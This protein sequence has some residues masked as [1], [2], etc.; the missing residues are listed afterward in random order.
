MIDDSRSSPAYSGVTTAPGPAP[1]GLS[2]S[3]PVDDVFDGRYERRGLLGVG[4]MGRVYLVWDR[5]VEREVALKEVYARDEAHRV[6]LTKRFLREAAVTA[7]LEHPGIVPVYDVGSSGRGAYYTMRV[8]RGRSLADRVHGAAPTE[9]LSLLRH[10]RDA[11]EALAFAHE[12]GVVHRDIKPGNIMI[13]AFGETLL[14]DWGL[15][16]RASDAVAFAAPPS[17]PIP[18]PGLTA[19]GAIVGTPQY[20]SPEQAA[21]QPVDARSDVYAMGLA[22]YE[23]I[24]GIPARGADATPDSARDA[25]TSVERLSAATGAPAELAAIVR[26]AT[27]AEPSARYASAAALAGD[28]T[29]YLEGRRVGAH[30]YSNVELLLRLLKAWRAPLIVLLVAMTALAIGL[31]Q[32]FTG[33]RAARDRAT[34]EREAALASASRAEAAERATQQALVAADRALSSAL[35]ERLVTGRA[36][37]DTAAAGALAIEALR[38]GSSPDARG[39]LAELDA[40]PLPRVVASHALPDC[41]DVLPSTRRPA[42]ICRGASTLSFWD[43]AP[44][45]R[46]WLRFGEH[47]PTALL[48][49]TGT[50]LSNSR[51]GE[52]LEVTRL[53]DGETLAASA[54]T[55]GARAEPEAT[56]ALESFAGGLRIFDGA[57]IVE[58]TATPC[59][60]PAATIGR[61]GRWFAIC[62]DG[63]YVTG[64]TGELPTSGVVASDGFEAHTVVWR[65]ERELVFGSS[66]G[67]L[68]RWDRVT[69]QWVGPRLGGARGLLQRLTVS[70]DGRFAAGFDE[71]P[72]VLVWDLDAGGGALRLP[73]RDA[74]GAIFVTEP[75]APV[76]GGRAPTLLTWNR[77]SLTEWA[78]PPEGP[79]VLHASGGVT[80]LVYVDSGLGHAELLAAATG[81]VLAR[82]AGDGRITASMHVPG[83]VKRVAL[84]GERLLVGAASVPRAVWFPSATAVFTDAQLVPMPRGLESVTGG[85][86]LYG[87]DLGPLWL[88]E[89]DGTIAWQSEQS[90]VTLDTDV[91]PDGLHV[92]IL[93]G[94][95]GVLR[96][97]SLASAPV[98]HLVSSNV[99]WRAVAIAPDSSAYALAAPHRV[100]VIDELGD[101]IDAF[102]TGAPSLLVE[103]AWSPAG[104]WIA[105]GARDGTT[106]LWDVAT[107]TLV[108]RL[109][110]Q[111]ER[112]A[113]LAFT[114]D[115]RGLAAGSWDRTIR[116]HRLDGLATP[117]DRLAADFETRSGMTVEE[118]LP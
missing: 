20:L 84:A 112:V 102:E 80:D 49:A 69:T 37:L 24:A 103:V 70:P 81:E 31:T 87:P 33:T 98:L 59:A 14:M 105:A 100:D 34:A 62:P 90:V 113:A 54:T 6:E 94:E 38:H 3:R 72:G 88:I 28:L 66:K 118:A 22:L 55:H 23:V 97:L 75:L 43:L 8:V 93:D 65:G 60:T 67:Q 26:R 13:G 117:V 50:V 114:A 15:A 45:E 79:A 82:R 110:A 40:A 42:A 83:V 56:T 86:V 109:R 61:H 92:A 101:E 32:A 44:L 17:A 36:E 108:A 41:L 91:T 11:C 2:L 51:A 48:E 12:H 39:V 116:L 107:G 30:Q 9:R 1:A 68:A 27:A 4:G 104:R 111:R 46:R 74:A 16:G 21:G 63:R 89:P 99:L 5:H 52:T 85:R 73:A 7:R 57:R 58:T 64:R 78:F 35:A 95:E 77:E 19:W 115:E 10:V 53:S 71:L 106:Y 29:A 25:V 76:W 96:H 47:V 18:E